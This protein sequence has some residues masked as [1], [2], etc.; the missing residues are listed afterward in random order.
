MTDIWEQDQGQLELH[1]PDEFGP[2]RP[3][4]QF[5]HEAQTVSVHEHVLDGTLSNSRDRPC[6]LDTPE[7]LDMM[8][9]GP[10]APKCLDDWLYSDRPALAVHVITF[11]DATFVTLNY[12]HSLVDGVG[13]R[14]IMTNWCKVLAG[15]LGDVTP[16]ANWDEDP[17]SIIGRPPSTNEERYVHEGNRLRGWHKWYWVFRFIADRFKNR[18]NY[19]QRN[20]FIPASTIARLRIEADDHATDKTYISDN[21]LLTAWLLRLACSPLEGSGRP[22]G[23]TSAVDLRGFSLHGLRPGTVY[24]QNLLAYTWINT[25]ATSL[26]C[27]PLGTAAALMRTSLKQQLTLPQVQAAAYLTHDAVRRTGTPCF[28]TGKDSFLVSVSSLAKAKYWDAVD[29]SPALPKTK[30]R[31]EH[32]GKPSWQSSTPRAGM[33]PSCLIVVQGSDTKGNWFAQMV[34]SQRTW[35]MVEHKLS[36]C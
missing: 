33:K 4:V 9:A 25:T 19:R 8:L 30:A 32:T 18:N 6:V 17:M 28:F 15:R 3:A 13:K 29:F 5:T 1:I 36:N 34:L 23:I 10:E 22:I 20:V 21:Q 12:S 16:L 2:K 35:D 27:S 24:M 26:L 14:E 31:G 11:V 7:E